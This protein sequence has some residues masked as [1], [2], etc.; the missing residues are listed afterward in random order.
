MNAEIERKTVELA[1]RNYAIELLQDED[2]EDGQVYLALH[3]ELKGCMA[4]GSTIEEAIENLKDARIDFIR[5]LLL[6][7][8]DVPQPSEYYGCTTASTGEKSPDTL[9]IKKTFDVSGF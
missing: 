6:D 4:Q 8:L 3:P 9:F 7:G 2:Q 5:S 1:S